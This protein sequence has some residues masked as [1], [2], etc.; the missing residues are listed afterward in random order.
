VLGAEGNI[1][2]L[3]YLTASRNLSASSRETL[4]NQ[5]KL[6]SEINSTTCR[7]VVLSFSPP[8]RARMATGARP[9]SVRVDGDD[10]FPDG[11]CDLLH[12]INC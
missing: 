11:I 5:G 2:V 1:F 12:R 8:S 9:L 6:P 10:D 4:N 3:L 7:S